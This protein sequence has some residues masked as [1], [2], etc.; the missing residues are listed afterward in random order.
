MRL[1][2]QVAVVTGAASGIGKEIAALFVREG[3]RV[4]IADH[5]EQ[6]AQAAAQDLG[7]PKHAIGVPVDVTD[8]A[9][10]EACFART[11]ETF[12]PVDIVVSNAGNQTVA[13]IEQFELAQWRKLRRSTS[14]VLLP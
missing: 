6:G 10:V 7:G 13:P 1:Y 12:G 8:E 14:T 3:A 11:V 9:Q 4:V 2:K 5:N